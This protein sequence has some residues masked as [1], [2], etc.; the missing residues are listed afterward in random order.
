MRS[1]LR[2]LI[3]GYHSL[4]RSVQ[5]LF[6]V[7]LIN[8]MGNFVFPFL[9][10]LL[11]IKLGYSESQA[12]RFMSGA[13]L[14]AGLGMLAGGKAGDH[15]GRRQT[16]AGLQISAALILGSCAVL[17]LVPLV[18]YL[19]AAAYVLLQASW[20]IFNALVADLTAPEK[21][22]QAYALLYWGNNI[23]FSVGPLLAGY[24][25]NTHARFMF[26][27]N[28]VSLTAASL[29][30]IL[31]VKSGPALPST[32]AEPA[33]AGTDE[34]PESGSLVQA[35][36]KRPLIL[37]FAGINL[38]LHFVYS[39]HLFGLPVFLNEILGDAGPACYGQVMTTNGL[40][41]VLLTGVV[42][43]V[44]AGRRAAV[45][46]VWAALLYAAGFGMLY[47]CFQGPAVLVSTVIWTLGEIISA[48]NIQVFIASRTPS[49]HRGRINAFISWV[50]GWGSVGAPVLAGTYIGIFGSRALWLPVAG[51]ALVA[52]VL[53]AVVA[54][55]DVRRDR[56]SA[57]SSGAGQP[58]IRR[59]TS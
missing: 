2:R 6:A 35:L 45:H 51:I 41:V 37:A 32:A 33:E 50:S 16:I 4:D 9:T 24:L 1:I 43:T 40:T 57:V 55:Y 11:T 42:G 46:I 47:F 14:L 17:G 38:L 59:H 34:A 26:I 5:V 36:L 8:S 28:A 12:G 53:M 44:L 29:L 13:A 23:G 7:R 54:R 58:D 31:V 56:F 22:K 19:I 21:R 18:P 49:S 52:A 3:S 25:F 39:Q 15:F 30:L 48:T 20:P 27:G 10:M